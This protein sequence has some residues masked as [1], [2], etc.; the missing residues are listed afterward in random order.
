M[1]KRIEAERRRELQMG[2]ARLDDPRK[3]RTFADAA[4]VYLET[5]AAHW[6]PRNAQIEAYNVD[7]LMPHFGKKLLSSITGDD[8][9]RFQAAC[10][11]LDLSPRTINMSI[12]SLRSILR[13]HRL[14]AFIEQDVR[15]LTVE[16]EIGRALS[17]DE[18]YRVLTACK[19]SRSRSLYPAVLTSIHT[20]LRNGELRNLR[21]RQIDLIEGF[22]TVGKSKTRAGS[23]RGIPL[24]AT[25]L[26][27]LKEWRQQ[28]PSALPD[29]FV[30]ASEAYC[31]NSSAPGAVHGTDPTRP[32]LSWKTGWTAARKAAGVSCRWHDLRHCFVSTL[33]EGQA[34]D[35]TI[36]AMSGHVSNKMLERYS[37]TRNE[38]KR[39]AIAVFDAPA[40]VEIPKV[41]TKDDETE[42]GR[43]Q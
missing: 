34:S 28:F 37:H 42:L 33:A 24:S 5:S 32:I 19:R 14:W 4:K 26:A 3:P 23:G 43:L 20:G 29:H 36:K 10:K 25:V 9:G 17:A 21:W 39:A 31:A 11:K 35:A 1:A 12:G 30:F 41:H 40:R 15:M 13:K 7:K 6:S 27:C 2:I 38:A 22:L 16:N 18:Q 8:I